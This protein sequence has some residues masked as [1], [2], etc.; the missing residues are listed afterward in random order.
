MLTFFGQLQVNIGQE[1]IEV[2]VTHCR[3]LAVGIWGFWVWLS[4]SK[5]I[6]PP[7][8][9]GNYIII[10]YPCKGLNSFFCIKSPS[11]L[12]VRFTRIQ[13]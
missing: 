2:E 11:Y 5:N 10:L 4:L 9:T 12:W 3:K 1:L 13:I 8:K 7:S 6:T